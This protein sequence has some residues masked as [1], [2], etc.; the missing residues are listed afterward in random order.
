MREVQIL[1]TYGQKIRHLP[2]KNEEQKGLCTYIE[3]NHLHK[4]SSHDVKHAT[5]I[6]SLLQRFHYGTQQPPTLGC[7]CVRPM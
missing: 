5:M 4:F 6:H 2:H 3:C 1:Q 7:A